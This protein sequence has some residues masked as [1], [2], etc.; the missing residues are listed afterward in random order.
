MR[1]AYITYVTEYP[2]QQLSFINASI[3]SNLLQYFIYATVKSF[4]DDNLHTDLI[5]P[6]DMS[7]TDVHRTLSTS[8]GGMQAANLRS[9]YWNQAPHRVAAFLK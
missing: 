7:Y 1:I 4:G 8:S 5:V 2:Q 9:G 3:S 6:A